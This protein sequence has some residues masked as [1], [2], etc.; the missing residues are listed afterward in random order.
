MSSA[1]SH[2]K[3]TKDEIRE[4]EEREVGIVN[5]DVIGAIDESSE[6][7]R[8]MTKRVVRKVRSSSYIEVS[9]THGDG[10]V[11]QVDHADVYDLVHLLRTRYESLSGFEPLG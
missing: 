11:R 3:D 2:E 10:L 1:D 8:I 6:E 5:P 4:L 7:Y 9:R